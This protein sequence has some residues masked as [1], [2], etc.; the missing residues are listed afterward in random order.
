ML[1][2]K[3]VGLTNSSSTV[4]DIRIQAEIVVEERVVVSQAVSQAIVYE[5]VSQAVVQE[6]VVEQG[7]V[8]VI[9]QS[10]GVAVAIE[11]QSVI[12]ELVVLGL[13]NAGRLT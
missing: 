5:V 6:V 4:E 13:G 12:S 8:V 7:I 3:C 10:A 2:P 1:V 11:A 9:Q